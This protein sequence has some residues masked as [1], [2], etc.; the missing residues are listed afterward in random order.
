M[1]LGFASFLLFMKCKPDAQNSYWGEL[2]GI[3]YKIND[4]NAAYFSFLW[5]CNDAASVVDKT[6]VDIDFWGMDLSELDGF[7]DDV[8][9]YILSLMNEG[10]L[11]TILSFNFKH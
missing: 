8:K 11:K 3:P 5:G 7:Q 9:K 6:F 4:D 1:A 10:I 2:N